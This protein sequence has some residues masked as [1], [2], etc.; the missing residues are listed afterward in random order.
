[1]S[2][3]RHRAHAGELG[4]CASSARFAIGRAELLQRAREVYSALD[5]VPRARDRREREAVLY[6]AR[7]RLAEIQASRWKKSGRPGGGTLTPREA[8]DGTSGCAS[9]AT[10]DADI[11]HA[12][13][14]IER[15][16]A[17]SLGPGDS[18]ADGARSV[19]RPDSVRAAL[20]EEIARVERSIDRILAC[21]PAPCRSHS[22]GEGGARSRAGLTILAALE[23]E[24]AAVEAT[25]TG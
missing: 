7:Q 12:Q 24:V 10:L 25:Q 17:C 9:R 13:E 23:M 19:A 21:S 4:T 2:T 18:H 16:V 22:H 20:D 6:R 8:H 3:G 5:E 14:Q 1:M 15:F 11:A